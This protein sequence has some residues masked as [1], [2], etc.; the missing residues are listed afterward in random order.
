[1]NTAQWIK[2]LI[3]QKERTAIPIMTHPGIELIGKRIVDAVTDGE[4]HFKAVEALAPNRGIDNDYGPYGR[5]G[6]FRCQPSYEPRRH[7]E[8]RRASNIGLCRNK[9]IAAPDTR[10]ETYSAVSESR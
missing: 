6:S 9:G 8:H 7:S 1:M 3:G 10:R 4:T 2:T 5:G